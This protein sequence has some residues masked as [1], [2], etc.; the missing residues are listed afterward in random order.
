MNPKITYRDLGIKLFKHRKF[1]EAKSMFSLAYE[2]NN[3]EEFLSFITLCEL[4][5]FNEDEAIMLF[6][7]YVDPK[8][9]E[10]TENINEV[11]RLLEEGQTQIYKELEY[12]DAITYH[13]FKRLVEQSGDFKSIFQNIMFSTKVVISNKDDLLEFVE[14]LIQNGYKDMGLNY[15]ESSAHIF[16]GDKRFEKLMSDLGMMR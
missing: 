7:F 5:K 14:N 2:F 13:D 10:Q 11:I 3:N 8:E 6:E 1:N 9:I 4:A 16:L 15:L 12:E